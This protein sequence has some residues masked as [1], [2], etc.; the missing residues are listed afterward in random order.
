MLSQGDL[1]IFLQ[2]LPQDFTIKLNTKYLYSCNKYSMIQFSSLIAQKI[3]E[4]KWYL[5]FHGI[6]IRPLENTI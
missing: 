2:Q 4:N 1:L 3:Q 6:R 5:F